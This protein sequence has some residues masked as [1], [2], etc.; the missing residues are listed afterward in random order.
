M[1]SV[2][3]EQCLPTNH[4]ACFCQLGAAY[5]ILYHDSPRHGSIANNHRRE[6][7]T[8]TLQ[9]LTI[10]PTYTTHNSDRVQ[11]PLNVFRLPRTD[12]FPGPYTL[13][14]TANST[15]GQPFSSPSSYLFVSELKTQSW[16][17]SF[18][19]LIHVAHA[20]VHHTG[21]NQDS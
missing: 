6:C 17:S 21:Q 3:L 7:S 15:H 12:I 2:S 14:T 10:V 1:N 19:S 16:T 9:F 13:T 4:L 18:L 5:E 20:C 8:P 11:F